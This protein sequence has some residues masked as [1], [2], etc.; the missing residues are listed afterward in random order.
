MTDKL[1]KQKLLDWLDKKRYYTEADVSLLLEQIKAGDFDA[2][3][4]RNNQS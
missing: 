2:K 4:K 1:D 3:E